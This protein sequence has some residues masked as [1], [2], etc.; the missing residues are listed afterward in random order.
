MLTGFQLRAARA[1]LS[2]H[3]KDIS[4]EV[5]IHNSTLTRLESITPNLAYINSTTR[6]SILIKNFYT[7]YGIVFPHYNSISMSTNTTQSNEFNRF[8]LKI[9][10]TALRLSRKKLGII[11]NIPE[12]TL[13]GWE[14][15]GSFFDPIKSYNYNINPI[16]LYFEKLGITY[17]Q[18]NIVELLED[19]TEKIDL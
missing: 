11:L 8:Q 6:I 12:A 10:R 7:N 13:T 19:P 5:G 2:L 17:P 4:S 3:L 15:E 18:S 9:S 16:K 1:C 14:H